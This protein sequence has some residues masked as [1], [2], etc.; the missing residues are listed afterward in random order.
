MNHTTMCFSNVVGPMEEIGF[1]GH[2]MA[3]LAPSVYGQPQVSIYIYMVIWLN[4]SLKTQIWKN[5]LC[6]LKV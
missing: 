6:G 1:Y 4:G 2:P 3:F 5:D